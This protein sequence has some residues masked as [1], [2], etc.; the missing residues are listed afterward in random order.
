MKHILMVDDVTTNLKCAA[1]VLQPYY[2]LSMAKSGKQALSFLKKNRPDLIL[3]DIAMPDMDGYQTMEEIK[4]NPQTADIP[5]IFLTADTELAS[6]IKGIKMGAMDFI[7]KPFEAQVM[8]GRIE[9]VLQMDEMRKNIFSS[10]ISD[11]LTGVGNLEYLTRSVNEYLNHHP[12]GILLLVDVDDFSLWK[13]GKENLQAEAYLKAVSD[14]LISF[15]DSYDENR[16]EK[17]FVAR[18]DDNEF[19]LFLKEPFEED[20]IGRLN[21]ILRD[22]LPKDTTYSVAVTYAPQQGNHL[23][24]LYQNADKAMYFLKQTQKNSYH[25]YK[26]KNSD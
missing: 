3:L 26:N 5:I 13:N 8:L 17:S 21:V 10:S 11:S 24:T 12:E 16:E 7:T 22:Y 9:K 20:K 18:T 19:A 4:L 23:E 25:I 1:E 6:E 15:C 14:A 2:Q